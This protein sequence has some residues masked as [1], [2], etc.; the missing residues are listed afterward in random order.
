[1]NVKKGFTLIELVVAMAIFFIIIAVAFTSI[2]RFYL[3]RTFYDQQMDLQQNFLYA[4]DKL[5]DDLRQATLGGASTIKKPE[6]K[7]MEE[8]LE[9]YGSD[10][11]LI[12]YDLESK[13]GGK[14]SAIYRK[15]NVTTQ[16]ITE[17]MHQLVKLYFIRQG[18]RIIAIIVGKAT[19][20]GT[21]N[22]VS[23]TSLIYSRNYLPGG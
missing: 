7:A 18:G 2:S 8:T 21:T 5:S 11:D 16:P 20:M 4:M 3:V 17:D 9:F 10:G 14:T 19:Y 1:M 13:D 23:F 22:T 15:D 6:D 12:T